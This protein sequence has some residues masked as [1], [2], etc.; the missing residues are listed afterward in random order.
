MRAF[1]AAALIAGCVPPE[2]TPDAGE[3]GGAA[4]IPWARAPDAA[5]LSPWTAQVDFALSEPGDATVTTGDRTDSAA[6]ATE[7]RFVFFNLA[8]ASEHTFHVVAGSLSADVAATL[9]TARSHRVRFDTTHGATAGQADWV[10]TGDYARF[11]AALSAT[12]RYAPESGGLSS[13]DGVS[14]LVLPEPNNWN[15]DPDTQAITSFLQAGGSVLAIADHW[16]SDRDQDGL[17]SP[18]VLNPLFASLS[19][20]IVFDNGS[21]VYDA[22]TNM[23]PERYAPGVEGPAGRVAKIEVYGGASMTL[24]APAR[25]TIFRPG[26]NRTTRFALLACAEVHSGRLCAFSDSSAAVNS[27]WDDAALDNDL[28]FVNLIAWLAREY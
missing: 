26:A 28:M 23:V 16:N 19:A 9:P 5:A 2:G 13:L 4:G 10:L 12:G 25:G 21:D 27:A 1:L 3:D 15:G 6:A 18:R 11:G 22:T 24:Q 14:V 8:P 20:G 17:D 7:H